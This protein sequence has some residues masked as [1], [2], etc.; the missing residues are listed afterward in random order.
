MGESAVWIPYC[1]AAPLPA[2]LAARWNF[3]P[4]LLGALTIATLLG[5]RFSA[6]LPATR[7]RSVLAMTL[8]FLL[9]VSPF[10]ALTSALFSARTLHHLALTALAAPL[11]AATLPARHVP[12]GWG[13]WAGAHAATFWL[14]HAPPAYEA[15]LSSHA[16]YWLMQASLLLTALALWRAVRAAPPTGA[17]FALLAT[18]VQM[19]L[20]GALLTFSATPFYAPH[21]VAPLAWGLSPLEDQQLAGLIMWAPGAGLYLAAA[22]TMLARWFSA[23]QAATSRPA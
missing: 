20:L 3:E 23:E 18:M 17:I 9:F 8:L 6:A 12:G 21:A 13:L 22:L 4:L 15:A 19:G 1:G 16:V 7:W 5:F 11:L 10:C 14:W 2:E